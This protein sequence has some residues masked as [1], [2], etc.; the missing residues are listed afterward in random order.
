MTIQAQF[1]TKKWEVSP[2]KVMTIEDDISYKS[3]VKTETKSSSGG[4]DKVVNK[5]YDADTLSFSYCVNKM[6]GCNPEKEYSDICLLVGKKGPFLLG[7]TRFGATI[8]MLKSAKPSDIQHTDSGEIYSM[9]IS[10]EFI[11]PVEGKSAAKNVIGKTA[12]DLKKS[13]KQKGI[14]K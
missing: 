4:K 3:S 8:W 6:A 2:E 14:K 11:E 12:K 1:L 9:K 10:L 7:G 5:G 13:A